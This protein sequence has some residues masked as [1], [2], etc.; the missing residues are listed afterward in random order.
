MSTD[1]IKP[2]RARY[3]VQIID[4]G[5]QKV[6]QE[7]DAHSESAADR[8]DRGVNINLHHAKYHTNILD[9]EAEAETATDAPR[10]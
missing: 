2:S 6:V 1:N 7:I 4:S 10:P 3:A 5:T 9:R 8:I